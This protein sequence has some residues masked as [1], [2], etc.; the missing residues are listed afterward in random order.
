MATYRK[1]VLLSAFAI[2]IALSMLATAGCSSPSSQAVSATTPPTSPAA[3]QTG[4]ASGS[5]LHRVYSVGE[6]VT[7]GPYTVC[8][9]RARL[10]SHPKPSTDLP[11]IPKIPRGKV[12]GALVVTV[13]NPA[14]GTA[15]AVPM[16]DLHGFRMQD[17]RGSAIASD[18]S[19]IGYRP[20][21]W[22]GGE[23]GFASG[24][25]NRDIQPGDSMAIFPLFLVPSDATSL[26]LFY[27]PLKELPGM[28]VKFKVK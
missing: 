14:S 5:N 24:P 8:L 4:S 26:T 15:E 1:R 13:A 2:T 27:A 16:P 17:G 10:L 20:P 25:P 11:A 22:P 18:T 3:S 12:L 21:P 19:G 9:T 6:T 7:V 23:T 28:V